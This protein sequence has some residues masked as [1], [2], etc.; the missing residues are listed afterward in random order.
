[1]TQALADLA[2]GNFKGV[3]QD[4]MA[5]HTAHPE[6]AMGFPGQHAFN[7]TQMTARIQT[8]VTKLSGQGVDV[9][10]VQAD[11]ASGNTTAAMQWIAAYHKAHPVNSGNK[12][13]WNGG[14]STQWQKSGSFHPAHTGFGNQTAQHPRFPARA[15]GA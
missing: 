9:S 8:E 10:T 1:M 14:N 6:V 4:L 13:A 2:T 5:I 3:M 12:T 15:Q 7:S 11:L